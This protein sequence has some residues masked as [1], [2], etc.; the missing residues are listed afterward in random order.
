MEAYETFH[1]AAVRRN[2]LVT[3]IMPAPSRL[4]IHATRLLQHNKGATRACQLICIISYA[5][6]PLST[7][8]R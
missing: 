4:L 5:G 2:E 1:L 3:V 7:S 8:G 6:L